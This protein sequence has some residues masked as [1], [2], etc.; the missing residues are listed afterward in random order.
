MVELL[1]KIE[2]GV[3]FSET[4]NNPIRGWKVVN[5]AYLLILKTWGMKK[6]YEKY[7]HKQVGQNNWQTFNDH[8]LQAYRQYQICKNTTASAHWYGTYKTMCITQTPK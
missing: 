8:V 4:T 2:E 6:S 7:K 5:I 3:D 1:E